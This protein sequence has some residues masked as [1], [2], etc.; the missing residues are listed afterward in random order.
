MRSPVEQVFE[1]CL[2]PPVAPPQTDLPAPGERWVL[3]A[4]RVDLEAGGCLVHFAGPLTIEVVGA[5]NVY[6]RTD[7]ARRGV[8]KLRELAA[9]WRR[10]ATPPPSPP[11]S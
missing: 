4:R 7:S 10:A 11:A 6:V 2:V 5:G 1:R 8:L 9:Y 3:R